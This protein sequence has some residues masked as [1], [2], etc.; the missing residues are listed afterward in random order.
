MPSVDYLRFMRQ[1][2]TVVMPG[3]YMKRYEPIV[4]PDFVPREG[5]GLPEWTPQ[6]EFQAGD[7][8]G[9]DAEWFSNGATD[10][11]RVDVTQERFYL[12]IY[13]AWLSYG[14]TIPEMEMAALT[15]TPLDTRR[16][17]AVRRTSERTIQKKV[18]FG[19]SELGW[20]GFLNSSQAT[21][22]D[23]AG[24]GT[25]RYWVNKTYD[26]IIKDFNDTIAGIWR[27]TKG[28]ALP[29]TCAI[30]AS[31]MQRLTDIIMP[32][33][34]TTLLSYI[35]EQNYLTQTTGRQLQIQTIFGLEDAGE[36]NSG[37]MIMYRQNPE[38]LSFLQPMELTFL[39]PMKK[40]H[41]IYEVPAIYRL[42]PF[43]I[44]QPLEVRYLD[45]ITA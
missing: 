2:A 38:V 8:V 45:Y 1:Q 13:E 41:L 14:Y 40:N 18:F 3:I 36:S 12:P 27:D 23:A 22:N 5:D 34:T 42:G 37:R 4:Y 39:E 30:P 32:N 17:D 26:A 20:Q 35:R 6:V 28:N 7:Y 33:T 31:A 19:D 25:A 15:Q 24:A 16:I 43:N 9:R 29:D 10:I 11:P 44:K 21:R